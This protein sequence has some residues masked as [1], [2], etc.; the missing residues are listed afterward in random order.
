[1][2]HLD[3]IDY[4]FSDRIAKHWFSSTPGLDDEIRNTFEP[5]WASAAKGELDTWKSTPE[6][7]LALI[8]ILDQFPLNMFRG[9]AKSFQTESRAIEITMAAIG[10][11]F[12]KEL[13]AD[14]LAFL[15][16]PLMHSEHPGDQDLSVELFKKHNLSGNLRFARHHRD[17]VRKF[18]RFPHRNRI[19]GR[20]STKEE[21]EYLASEDA[22]KG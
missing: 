9:K 1:M 7:C 6:G 16:M 14:K 8:I 19:L 11:G 4:W 12:D 18:G 10:N 20:E 15:F 17:I 22:F 21:L 3:I 2:N 5:T 13:S